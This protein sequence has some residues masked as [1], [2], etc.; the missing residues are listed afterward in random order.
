[1]ASDEL[2]VLGCVG[3]TDSVDAAHAIFDSQAAEG[4]EVF[5]DFSSETGEIAPEFG[6]TPDRFTLGVCGMMNRDP[7]GLEMIDTLAAATETLRFEKGNTI[8]VLETWVFPNRDMR[9][10]AEESLNL[11]SKSQ[12]ECLMDGPLFTS[13]W[14]DSAIDRR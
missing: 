1:M 10:E 12:K 6:P 5:V 7:L 3:L 9:D 11:I 4:L 14:T 13:V 8:A 2:G